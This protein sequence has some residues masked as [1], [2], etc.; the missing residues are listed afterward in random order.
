MFIS[1]S[2]KLGGSWFDMWQSVQASGEPKAFL[3][4]KSG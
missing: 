1:S 2:W 4:L 3:A